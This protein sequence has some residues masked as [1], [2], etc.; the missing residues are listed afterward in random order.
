M[1]TEIDSMRELGIIEP[2]TSPY[3][4][5][6][7]IVKKDDSTLRFFCDYRSLNH[8]TVF[9]TRQMPRIDDL[10]N[11]VRKAK[12]ISKVDLT[13]GYWQIPLDEDTKQKTAF[14]TLM[15]HCQFTVMSFGMVNAP[16]TFVRLGRFAW[17][18]SVFYRWYWNLQ[19][20]LG[21]HLEYLWNCSFTTVSK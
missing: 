8:I 7:V 10:L 11:K 16:A 6:V 20:D 17:F 14:V 9:D 19:R 13:K 21:E 2:S 5:T 4:S 15:G 18:C 1:K 3:A 12:Y